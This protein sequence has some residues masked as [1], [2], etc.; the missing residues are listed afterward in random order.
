M[1][2]KDLDSQHLQILKLEFECKAI[3]HVCVP[4]ENECK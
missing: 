2:K 4:R 3:K 1:A